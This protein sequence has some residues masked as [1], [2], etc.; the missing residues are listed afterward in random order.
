MPDESFEHVT[1]RLRH[2]KTVPDLA[3]KVRQRLEQ[4]ATFTVGGSFENFAG[5]GEARWTLKVR[6]REEEDEWPDPRRIASED[7][8]DTVG[9]GRG[10]WLYDRRKAKRVAHDAPPRL[11]ELAEDSR[12]EHQGGS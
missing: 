8:A 3:I 11:R 12:R 10:R 4:P 1:L 7:C 5:V 2:R 6:A 9:S